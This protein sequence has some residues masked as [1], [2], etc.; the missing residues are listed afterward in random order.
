MV[1]L[2]IQT[3]MI[4]AVTV[5]QKSQWQH[6]IRKKKNNNNQ[7]IVEIIVTHMHTFNIHI[8]IHMYRLT[9]ITIATI[10]E[11]SS[12]LAPTKYLSAGTRMTVQQNVLFMQRGRSTNTYS[13][14]QK[15]TLCI[16]MRRCVGWVCNCSNE[17][18][19]NEYK[20]LSS[21]PASQANKDAQK[22]RKT[23]NKS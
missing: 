18:V 2:I 8:Y 23:I 12:K 5:A 20:K 3:L 15:L 1:N 13:H 17:W 10:S 9:L 21:Q 7:P 22:Q 6:C 19:M 4:E 11:K 14:T 16:H